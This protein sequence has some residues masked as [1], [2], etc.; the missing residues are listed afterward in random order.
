MSL[1]DA[2]LESAGLTDERE[3]RIV[4]RE[5]PGQPEG[6]K[7]VLAVRDATGVI[8]MG[9]MERDWFLSGVQLT[10]PGGDGLSVPTPA[11]TQVGRLII[12]GTN[13]AFV[14]VIGGEL[15]CSWSQAL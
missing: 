2:V 7:L 10:S 4:F 5:I 3:F 13:G 11:A 9:V 12:A 6:M 1:H 14:E 15:D 8:M